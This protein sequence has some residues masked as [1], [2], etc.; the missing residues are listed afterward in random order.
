VTREAIDIILFIGILVSLIISG[1]NVSELV[2]S[3][4]VLLYLR[5]WKD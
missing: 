5:Q 2:A 4:L 1:F 3:G